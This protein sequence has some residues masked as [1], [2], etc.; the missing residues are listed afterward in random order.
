MSEFA[1][2]EQQPLAPDVIDRLEVLPTAND[3]RPGL[4]LAPLTLDRV[5]GVVLRQLTD[6]Y[7]VPITTE[8]DLAERVS[9]LH[10]FESAGLRVAPHLPYVNEAGAVIASQFIE[11]KSINFLLKDI[12][13]TGLDG[14]KNQ[15][16]C[17]AV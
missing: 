6:L 15:R 8:E 16:D 2:W 13:Q 9:V 10:D 17:A 12:G 11:G 5:G 4:G 7:A 3:E 1:F 14:P